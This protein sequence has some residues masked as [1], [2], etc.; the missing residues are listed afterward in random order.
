MRTLLEIYFGINLIIA[1][2]VLGEIGW[3]STDRERV[4]TLLSFWLHVLIGVLVL[5][6]VLLIEPVFTSV[7][8]FF[9]ETLQIQFFLKYIF[10]RKS[11]MKVADDQLLYVNRVAHLR[12]KNTLKNR[13]WKYSVGLLNKYRNYT[14]VHKEETF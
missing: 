14:Y 10:N 6:Y 13:I 12:T 3:A 4:Y 8:N 1:G 2:H 7:K 11:L 5:I 9:V